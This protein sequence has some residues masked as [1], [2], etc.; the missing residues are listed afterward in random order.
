MLKRSK[1]TKHIIQVKTLK[2]SIIIALVIQLSACSGHKVETFIL[3]R[4]I[5]RLEEKNIV[6]SPFM[7]LAK[8]LFRIKQQWSGT[9][10]E[11]L[12]L[13]KRKYY[14]LCT[15]SPVMAWEIKQAPA[16]LKIDSEGKEIPFES[17]VESDVLSWTFH[18]GEHEFDYF[19]EGNEE[20]DIFVLDEKKVL[21]KRILLPEGDFILQIWAEGKNRPL[22]Q[23][24][25]RIELNNQPIDTISIGP[26]DCYKMTGQAQF[27]MNKISLIAENRESTNSKLEHGVLI[28][29]ISVKSLK[30]IILISVPQDKKS[31]LTVDYSAEYIAEP[32][33]KS[34]SFLARMSHMSPLRDM[35]IKDN[36]FN[37]KK[38]LVIM[39]FT[40]NLSHRILDDAINVLL[41]PPHSRF[42]YELKLPQACVLEFGYGIFSPFWRDPEAEVS[43]S[44]VIQERQNEEIL[45]SE[46]LA[47]YK[48]KFYNEA[49]KEKIDLSR[50][51][52]KNV[53][54]K[55]ITTSASG[56]HNHQP[57]K[58]SVP[59]D[60]EFAYW[61]NPIIYRKF[62]SNSQEH[63][64]PNI[65]LISLDTLRADHLKC[66]GYRRETSPHMDQLGAEGALFTNAFSSTSWTLP[67]HISLF[68]SLDN[69]H[70]GVDKANP[71]LDSSIIT[72]ADMLRKKEYFT[73]AI[74]G[75]AL[76]SQRFGFSKG[77]DFYREFKRSR[78][79]PNSAKILYNHVNPWLNANKNKR[80]FLFLHTYQTHAP[81]TCPP[82]FNSSFFSDQKMPWTKGDI[83]EILFGSIR[84][85]KAPFNTLSRLERENIVALYDGEIRFID[86][87]LIKPLIKQLKKLQLYENTMIILTS[88]H[89]EE[90][91]DHKAWLHGHS[92]YNELL[93]IPMII[94]FPQSKYKNTRLHNIVSI[95][96]IMPTILDEIDIDFS[97]YDF[98]GVSLVNYL[99][100]GEKEEQLLIADLDS[101]NPDILPVKIALFQ[102]GYKLIMSNDFGK[103]PEFYLPVPPPIAKFELYDMKKDPTETHNLFDQKSTI[104]R[105]LM[106]KIPEI[107]QVKPEMS[108][109][110]RKSRDKDFEETMRALG[111]IR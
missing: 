82:P 88:D 1:R 42:E 111:Y 38:K 58:A 52:N 89:G 2:I 20:R 31:F 43:F 66:Y 76:V 105:D 90:F 13:N 44:V 37:L 9:K 11:P 60:I 73:C 110:K 106:S 27:G 19:K 98:D 62:F 95:V 72:L 28:D 56:A 51:A 92:L 25:L 74:T 5:D 57:T 86:E 40:K 91:F 36:P 67:A 109:E 14:A 15:Q 83:E 24:K 107:Y 79:K 34:S 80:F 17:S 69:R 55:F 39:G 65:I 7:D 63:I 46:N 71:Y 32:E 103:P 8:R 78:H 4:F 16:V 99:K 21:E 96:D 33:D 48:K 102:N 100:N 50:Y 54:I 29:R 10:F 59:D 12:L 97:E 30:D 108:R 41:A 45:F 81:Y 49:F 93:R 23:P 70:H 35:P 85:G 47:P 84:Q 77:F 87:I 6:S 26:Y 3:Y 18:K 22:K 94:K 61:E 68:T 53:I 64:Q 75:G 101:R 104:I